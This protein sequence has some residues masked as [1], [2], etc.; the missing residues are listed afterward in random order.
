MRNSIKEMAIAIVAGSVDGSGC[1]LSEGFLICRAL[2]CF[3]RK[4]Q[5][6]YYCLEILVDDFSIRGNIK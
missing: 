1:F 3:L 5:E 4:W 2:W 6:R